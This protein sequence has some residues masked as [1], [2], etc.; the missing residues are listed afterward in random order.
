MP[1]TREEL[2]KAMQGARELLAREEKAMKLLQLFESEKLIDMVKD[3]IYNTSDPRRDFES[4]N[5][6][7]E[8]EEYLN[9]D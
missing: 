6:I 8:V 1:I 9:G 5:F 2:G 4:S 7:A 3:N